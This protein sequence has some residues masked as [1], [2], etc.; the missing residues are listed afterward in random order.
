LHLPINIDYAFLTCK[1][2]DLLARGGVMFE[3]SNPGSGGKAINLSIF[4]GI[5]VDY[6][7]YKNIK[8]EAIPFLKIS[9]NE[10]FYGVALSILI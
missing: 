4:S 7:L 2:I 8:I 6:S 1:R 3:N 5:G 9:S 10:S